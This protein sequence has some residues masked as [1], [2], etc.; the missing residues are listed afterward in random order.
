M[1]AMATMSVKDMSSKINVENAVV[2]SDIIGR[3]FRNEDVNELIRLQDSISDAMLIEAAVKTIVLQDK[4]VFN[5]L[6]SVC[7][8]SIVPSKAIK[9]IIGYAIEESKLPL[10]SIE[11]L[12]SIRDNIINAFY[13]YPEWNHRW[14]METRLNR[15]ASFNAYLDVIKKKRS[16]V[17]I[18]NTQY[19]IISRIVSG[20]QLSKVYSKYFNSTENSMRLEC[21]FH[22]TKMVNDL[23]FLGI[24]DILVQV[25]GKNGMIVQPILIKTIDALQ[26]SFASRAVIGKYDLQAAYYRDLLKNS[27][28]NAHIMPIQFLVDS[29]K[30]P[31][32]PLLYTMSEEYL[33]KRN[34]YK[35][36]D[37]YMKEGKY[38]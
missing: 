17:A 21:N 7:K 11:S 3:E 14:S 36:L 2:F 29:I 35:T 20:I 9:R 15:I 28:P 10:D 26:K 1:N 32:N 23:T 6:F 18:T 37:N 38:E 16:S 22:A 24:I 31:G 27:F 33:K 19:K 4:V 30:K 5:H 8:D 13:K 12:Y 25:E 34:S